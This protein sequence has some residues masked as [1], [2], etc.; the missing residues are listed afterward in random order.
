MASPAAP[1]VSVIHLLGHLLV[2]LVQAWPSSLP[3]PAVLTTLDLSTLRHPPRWHTADERQQRLQR[4]VT[5][6]QQVLAAATPA[7]ATCSDSE[8]ASLDV[9]VQ[10]IRKVIA[11]ETATDATGRMS[12]RPA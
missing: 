7:L 12:E 11:D 2:R 10:A 4:V 8:R 6:A 1:T 5:T 3:L 9:L